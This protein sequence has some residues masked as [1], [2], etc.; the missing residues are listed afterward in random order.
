MRKP[1]KLSKQEY[2]V[3]T[4]HLGPKDV[5]CG[6]AVEWELLC[7]HLV[8]KG[9]L[10]WKKTY[11]HRGQQTVHGAAS[12]TVVYTRLLTDKGHAALEEK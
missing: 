2:S 10:E 11:E 6:D 8:A 5:F 3:L 12:M 1:M 9:M 4:C 7:E